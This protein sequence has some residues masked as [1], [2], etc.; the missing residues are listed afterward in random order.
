MHSTSR[1]ERI[2]FATDIHGSEICWRKFLGAAAYYGARTLILGGDMT[3][4]ALVPIV[5]LGSGKW[6]AVLLQQAYEL[7]SESEVLAVETSISSRGYYPFRTDEEAMAGFAENPDSIDRLFHRTLLEAAA[8][9]MEIAEKKLFGSGVRC[10]VCPG[11][12]DAFEIDGIIAASRTV[13]NAEGRRI[14]LGEGFTMASTGWS[15][16][17]PWKTHR[18]AEEP[19]LYEKLS[20]M[21]PPD[22]D[23]SRWIFNLHAPP[24]AT[25]LDDAPELDA[26]LNVKNA[27]Q[28]IV[29]VGSTAVRRIIEERR[30]LLS[31]HGHIHEAKA[32]A[33]IG[34]TLCINPG[35]LYEQGVLQGAVID[36]D[37]RKGIRS[38]ALTTG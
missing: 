2:F 28:N 31:L 7:E 13:A 24:R 19:E 37:R 18:E 3:G 8:K 25:G 9:W 10:F 22:A 14:D 26:N 4:K 38:Y 17:T 29:S 32:V 36:L 21:I 15:N 5:R 34:K 6:R 23:C 1:T 16:P 11:N 27:G 33:R 30:P 20:A 35:S 12:D